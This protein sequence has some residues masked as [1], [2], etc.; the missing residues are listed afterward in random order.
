[1]TYLVKYFLI[2]IK[3]II[4]YLLDDF[5]L[6]NDILVVSSYLVND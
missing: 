1:M 5:Y 2:F 4:F 3:K 6:E